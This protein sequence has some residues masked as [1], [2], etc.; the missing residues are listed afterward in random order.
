M[1]P[2][3]EFTS[4]GDCGEIFLF[5]DHH[6][7][8]S[9]LGLRRRKNIK[10]QQFFARKRTGCMGHAPGTD[11][12]VAGLHRNPI[13]VDIHFSFTLI[14]KNNFIH[15]DVDMPANPFGIST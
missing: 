1:S 3:T 8:V 4:I 15:C 7:V 2:A 6:T 13:A 12:Q 11:M 14:H 9:P 10:D 5:V